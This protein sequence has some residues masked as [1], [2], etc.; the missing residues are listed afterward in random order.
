MG[1]ST[2][3]RKAQ[4]GKGVMGSKK[5]GSGNIDQMQC[6]RRRYLRTSGTETQ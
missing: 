1:N 2:A 4:A 3:G 6:A 5:E